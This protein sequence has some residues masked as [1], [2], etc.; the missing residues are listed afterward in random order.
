M[1]TISADDAPVKRTTAAE[2][3]L[4]SSRTIA[5]TRS[6]MSAGAALRATAVAISCRASHTC[7]C[8]RR[9]V[10]STATTMPAAASSSE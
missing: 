9:S 2:S 7:C 1:A 5:A 8:C 4:N 10:T 6:E 3:T